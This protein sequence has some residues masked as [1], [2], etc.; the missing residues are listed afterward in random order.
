MGNAVII[1]MRLSTQWMD[2]CQAEHDATALLAKQALGWVD[3]DG[4]LVGEVV[5][6]PNELELKD[7]LET[8]K[9]RLEAKVAGMTEA[10][11]E[12][13][14]AV[15]CAILARQLDDADKEVNEKYVVEAEKLRVALPLQAEVLRIVHRDVVR[16]IIPDL[17]KLRMTLT[18]KTPMEEV[19]DAPTFDGKASSYKR[20][21][22]KFDELITKQFGEQAQIE[23]L[24]KA[25]P[26]VAKKKLSM[27][28][29][30]PA[31]VW[32]QLEVIYGDPRV[33]VKEAMMALHKLDKGKGKRILWCT[34]QP[35]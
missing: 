6:Q 20:F 35:H 10:V 11:N 12:D 24:D 22:K 29:K 30:T 19:V 15:Q 32:E 1:Y 28:E 23:Y 8:I 17:D 34:S 18:R 4:A 3:A 16:K 27:I 26:Q 2:E 13:L 5:A 31:Q 33:I 21:R 7:N 14:N 9:L 25:L